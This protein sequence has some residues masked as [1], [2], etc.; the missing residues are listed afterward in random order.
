[1]RVAEPEEQA[2]Q[3]R[4]DP[5]SNRRVCARFSSLAPNVAKDEIL[6]Q[7]LVAVEG[8][9][10]PAKSA[11]RAAAPAKASARHS[12]AEPDAEPA[13]QRDEADA[14][15][16]ESEA[17]LDAEQEAMLAE[18]GEMTQRMAPDPTTPCFATTGVELRDTQ[19]VALQKMGVTLVSDWSPAITHLVANTFRRTPKMLCAI[20]HGAHIVTPQYIAECRKKGQL[21]DHR[22]FTLRDEVCEPAFAKKRGM[23]S[24]SLAAA[25]ALRQK[26][27]PLLKG[28]MVHCLPSVAERGELTSLVVSAGG[29]WLAKFPPNPDDPSVLLLGARTFCHKR[30]LDKRKAH[31]VYDVELLRE[32]ACTQVLRRSAY[33]LR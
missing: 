27:G 3:R 18:L 2:S 6:S 9:S 22:E 17:S 7:Q 13:T 28:M 15:G 20:C 8:P 5:L 19:K 12:E 1:M 24:Y 4:G 26:N 30:E 16:H 11:V 33:L 32:A 23:S 10:P 21:V 14:D 29:Q 31:K 25:L